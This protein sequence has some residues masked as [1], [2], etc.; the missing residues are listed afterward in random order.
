[1][2][3]LAAMMM[4]QNG[5]YT[6][7]F[8]TTYV[9]DSYRSAKAVLPVVQNLI[10]PGR[11]VDVGCGLG[12]WLRVW[13]ELGAS[14]VVGIDGNYVKRDELQVRS[15]TFCAMDLS[16]PHPIKGSPFDL[17]QSLEVA[18]HLPQEAA[19]RFV[20]FLCS[21]SPVV[22][23]SAAIPSQGGTSHINEQWPEYW[24]ALFDSNGYSVFDVIRPRIWDDPNV[25]YYYAQNALLFVNNS[26][27][28][29]YQ[30]LRSLE[31]RNSPHA[32]ARVHPRKWEERVNT[33]PQFEQLLAAMPKSA[34]QFARRIARRVH[35]AVAPRPEY[36]G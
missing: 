5:P 29:A 22:L 21:L 24:A 33:V 17:A 19:S 13:E 27:I 9:A 10:Q 34:L 31:G 23:F 20:Q 28:N 1:V 35:R 26:R 36:V 2:A 16:H 11:V 8:F 30:A 4:S 3:E 6:T 12:T 15:E 32:L 14:T 25:A 18:E 7:T